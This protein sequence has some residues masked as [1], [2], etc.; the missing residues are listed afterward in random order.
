MVGQLTLY[1]RFMSEAQA[2]AKL[3]H[4]N[5][6]NIH[7]PGIREYGAHALMQISL[8]HPLLIKYIKED[9][10]KEIKRYPGEEHRSACYYLTET[11]K[12]HE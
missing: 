4:P 1:S 7:E 10:E 5:I 6:V 2:T 12:K 3:N 9:I 8:V 11:L